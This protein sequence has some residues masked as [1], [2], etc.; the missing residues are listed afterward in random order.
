VIKS[1]AADALDSQPT[2][3]RNSALEEAIQAIEAIDDGEAP[4]YR[5]CQEAIS[6]LKASSQ[7]TDGGVRNG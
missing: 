3:I 2:A 1:R 7:P 6:D 4:E 5:A